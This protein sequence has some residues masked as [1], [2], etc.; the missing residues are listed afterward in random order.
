MRRHITFSVFLLSFL[1][2]SWPASG[3]TEVTASAGT[4]SVSLTDVIQIALESGSRTVRCG[5]RLCVR[6]PSVS[7]GESVLARIQCHNCTRSG[8][9]P[10]EQ[11]VPG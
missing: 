3:Q 1:A 7:Q 5:G 2:L 11:L 10:D 9:R 6:A 4:L 8:A